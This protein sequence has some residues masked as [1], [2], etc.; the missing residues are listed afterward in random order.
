M[1]ETLLR[2][3]RLHEDGDLSSAEAS[4]RQVLSKEP[5][6]VGA[7]CLLGKLLLQRDDFRDAERVLRG[8]LNQ[9]PRHAEAWGLLGDALQLRQRFHDAIHAYQT[10][11]QIDGRRALLWNNLGLALQACAS[12]TRAQRCYESALE[13]DPENLEA[14]YNLG[15]L[16]YE[17]GDFEGAVRCYRGALQVDPLE[18]DAINNLGNA[19]LAAGR[20]A[21]A[22]AVYQRG[23]QIEP[24]H[25]IIR[26]NLKLAAAE[27]GLADADQILEKQEEDAEYWCSVGLSLQRRGDFPGAI[28]AYRKTLALEPE[29]PTARHL[30]DALTGARPDRAPQVYVEGLFNNYAPRFEGHL[31]NQLGYQVPALMRWMTEQLLGADVRFARMLDLGCGTGLVGAEFRERVDHLVGIDLSREMLDRCRRKELYDALYLA[32][33]LEWLDARDETF[34]LAT[35]ADVIIYMGDLSGL[36]AG[37]AA[38]LEPDGRF[39]ISTE[40]LDDEAAEYAL[41]HTGR[42]AH[43]RGYIARLA[44]QNGLVIEQQ[45][46][47]EIRRDRRGWTVG[48]VIMMRRPADPAQSTPWPTPSR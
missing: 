2:A 20:P 34:S 15:L 5:D 18:I 8:A 26:D 38:H 4:Y 19:L 11:L 42:Y 27:G 21:E 7:T 47:T 25:E 28:D 6:N 9:H 22:A 40:R 23:L 44:Q 29:E 13:R 48:D 30:L 39:L 1:N 37:V 17:L 46:S 31:V 12:Y 3:L 35:A 16:R 43:A 24:N 33:F 45:G 41:R 14:L 10:A 36:F 32:D